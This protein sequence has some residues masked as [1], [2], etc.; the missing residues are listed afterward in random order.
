MKVYLY[1]TLTRREEEFKPLKDGA[2]SMYSCGPTVYNYAHIGNMRTYVF[3]DTLTRMLRFFG[4]DVNSIM[5][6]TDVGHLTDDGDNGA[7]KMAQA[8]SREKKTPWEIAEYY[9]SVFLEDLAKL[10]IVLPNMMP[11]VTDHIDEMLDFVL[12]LQDKGFTYETSD[13]IYFDISKFPGYGKLSRV[14]LDE[15]LAGARVEVNEETKHPADFALWTKAPKEHIMQWP[16]PWGMSYPGWHIECSTLCYKYL[17]ERLD[18]HT[19]GVDHIPIH[20]ENEIAQ[21]EALFG[22]PAVNYWLHAEFMMVNGGKMS[23]SLGNTYTVSDL[24]KMG[25]HPLAFRYFCLNAHYRNKLNFT[26]D[27]MNAAQ[28]AYKRFLES[29]LAHKNAADIQTDELAGMLESFDRFVSKDLNLPAALGILWNMARLP[30]KSKQIYDALCR[31]DAIMGLNVENC[32]TIL[33]ELKPAEADIPEEIKQLVEQRQAARAEKNWAEAD[34]LRD[35][36]TAAGYA[37]KDSA[38]GPRIEKIN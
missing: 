27:A 1:N 34:R 31:C 23:K 18:I 29:A 17:G 35:Q 21:S 30:V 5:N 10:N 19:G 12:A 36:I 13:G 7:D 2:V 33:K 14:N 28:T 15:Q 6:I 4:Y 16:S 24:A 20:H 38:D 9:T 32:E 25:Y 37:V 22:H 8:A 11:R 26:F 3:T